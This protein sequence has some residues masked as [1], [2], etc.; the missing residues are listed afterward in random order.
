M[1]CRSRRSSP[2][3]GLRNVATSD[4][5]NGYSP[6]C[7]AVRHRYAATRQITTPA[8]RPAIAARNR[9]RCTSR[10]I[11]RHLGPTC[12]RACACFT[13]RRISHAAPRNAIPINFVAMVRFDSPPKQSSP[14]L[15]H[16]R[17][18]RRLG[19]QDPV[20]LSAAKNPVRAAQ[21]GREPSIPPAGAFEC[22]CV[23]FL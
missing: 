19:P 17:P 6:V 11:G 9:Q 21:P 2:S 3:P 8:I 16:H 4:D 10:R 5:V 23:L 22:R 20:I 7:R 18:P 1:E 12:P 13:S 15:H 14:R